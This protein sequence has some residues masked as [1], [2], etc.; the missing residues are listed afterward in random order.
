MIYIMPTSQKNEARAELI[1]KHIMKTLII[2]LLGNSTTWLSDLDK[3]GIQ[4]F[5][6]K[7]RGVFSADRLPPLSAS[8]PYAIINLDKAA[9]PGSHWV[10]LAYVDGIM[11]VYDSFGRKTIDILPDLPK[12]G[13]V[14]D[15]DY[16]QD[17]RII[18][19]NCG[20]RCLSWLVMVDSWGADMAM[21]I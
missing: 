17:Q 6:R 20:Q 2:P 13:P 8:R 12:M 19:T 11:H 1:Y 15:S 14:L 10:A 4:L 18:E 21:L 7:M 3:V 16:D 5:G 9:E